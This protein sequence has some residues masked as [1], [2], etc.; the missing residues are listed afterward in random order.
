MNPDVIRGV[1]MRAYSTFWEE[2]DGALTQRAE[3]RRP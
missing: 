2:I 1:I 3:A